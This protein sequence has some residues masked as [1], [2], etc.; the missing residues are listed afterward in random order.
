MKTKEQILKMLNAKY[1][2]H[3]IDQITIVYKD[4]DTSNME[5]KNIAI[6]FN[7]GPI[8]HRLLKNYYY[9]A[10]YSRYLI[11]R[12][13]TLFDTIMKKHVSFQITKKKGSRT[14]GY[15]LCRAKHDY[16]NSTHSARHRLMARAFVLYPKKLG[17]LIVNHID[18][19]PGN[20]NTEN[21]EWVTYSENLVHAL[22][23]NLMPNSL[24]PITLKDW[25]HGTEESFKSIQDAT[26]KT[27]IPYNVIA[28]RLLYPKRKY[29]DGLLVK[30]GTT[31]SWVKL[32][33]ELFRM[34]VKLKVIATHT[35]TNKSNTYNSIMD[36]SVSTN[37]NTT[38]ISTSCK[39][40]KVTK[41]FVFKFVYNIWPLM[42]EIS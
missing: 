36:A 37:C 2:K 11:K 35:V 26:N 9:I 40:G 1:P 13:G 6:R 15:R 20:D 33:N 31:A 5:F 22:N 28:K 30:R 4:D 42:K 18:G 32:D 41:Q 17:K 34:G 8:E 16:L 24:V 21:L 19:I 14:N 23:N 39:T 3:V 29:V 7:N 38:S 10:E 12:D 27:G 25:R